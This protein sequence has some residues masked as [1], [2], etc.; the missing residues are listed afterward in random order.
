[1]DHH[2]RL[3]GIDEIVRFSFNIIKQENKSPHRVN[4]Q[5]PNKMKQ[6]TYYSLGFWVA[7]GELMVHDE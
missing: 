5:V 2:A 1:M 7:S 6:T 3:P 4:A